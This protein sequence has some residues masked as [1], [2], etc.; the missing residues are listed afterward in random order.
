MPIIISHCD[1]YFASRAAAL[2]ESLRHQNFTDEIVIYAHDVETEVFFHEK[3]KDEV[4]VVSVNEVMN[5]YTHLMDAKLFRPINEFFFL[6]TPFIVKYSFEK[7]GKREVWYIDADVCL[8]S[9]FKNLENQ[10]QDSSILITPHNFPDR[11]RHLEKYGK[12]NVGVVFAK[13]DD[14][15]IR[16]VNWWAERCT[17]STE[18]KSSGEIYGDQKYLDN[19]HS[20]STK[21]G[22]FKGLGI[23]AAPWNSTGIKKVSTEFFCSDGSILTAYHF[24][25]LRKF[26]HLSYLG[27]SMYGW[28]MNSDTKKYVYIPYLMQLS[29]IERDYPAIHF[30]ERRRISKNSFFKMLRFR[31][32]TFELNFKRV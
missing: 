27:F 22:T 29:N 25:G 7:L 16:V 24:S 12:F 20:I 13:S 2:V 31:D 4:L 19:F 21:V 30:V 32:F 17:E 8:F 15:G 9:S 10:A 11:L 6:L 1:K 23:N 28:A 5:T 3:Y 14:D 26:K 18:L